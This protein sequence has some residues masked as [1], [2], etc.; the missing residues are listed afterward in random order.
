M[1]GRREGSSER[2]DAARAPA[3]TQAVLIA[4]EAVVVGTE[5]DGQPLEMAID[6]P[7]STSDRPLAGETR[8]V[9]HGSAPCH[10]AGATD[11][12]MSQLHSKIYCLSGTRN[13]GGIP[14]SRRMTKLTS[15]RHSR[16]GQGREMNRFGSARWK[17]RHRGHVLDMRDELPCYS[18][19]ASAVRCTRSAIVGHRPE[20]SDNAKSS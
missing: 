7:S 4:S 17:G 3:D 6:A 10:S 19:R 14:G 8:L 9:I 16:T 12:G 13:I 15:S 1:E 18:A 11:G 20:P 2:R 5:R